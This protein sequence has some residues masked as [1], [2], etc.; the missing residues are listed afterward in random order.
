LPAV[1]GFEV[2]IARDG[3]SAPGMARG[4]E[5]DAILLDIGLPGIDGYEVA[6]RLLSM[7]GER[8]PLL[9]ATSGYGQDRNCER[10]RLAR[11]DYYLV[12]PSTMQN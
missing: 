11:F 4:F 10:S 9:A 12:K 6:G 1:R 5:P 3:N 2:S 7:F 8:K